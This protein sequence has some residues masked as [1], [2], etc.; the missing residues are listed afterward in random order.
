[1]F[2]HRESEIASAVPGFKQNIVD[3]EEAWPRSAWSDAGLTEDEKDSNRN[4][5]LGVVPCKTLVIAMLARYPSVAMCVAANS[6]YSAD[7]MSMLMFFRGTQWQFA[8]VKFDW[9][10]HGRVKH[11]VGFNYASDVHK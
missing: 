7:T 4:M 5:F 9:G 6:V 1:M 10:A 3:T 8:S 11:A 2:T